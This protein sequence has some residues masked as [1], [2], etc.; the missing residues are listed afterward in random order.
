M[1]EAEINDLLCIYSSIQKTSIFKIACFLNKVLE[2][3][4]SIIVIDVGCAIG[5]FLGLLNHANIRS[6]GI[7]P[8]HHDYS[9]RAGLKKYSLLYECAIDHDDN[10]KLFN[11]TPGKDCSSL[12]DFNIE[13]ITNDITNTKNFYIPESRMIDS[14]SVVEKRIVKCK[15][16]KSIITENKLETC[17]IHILKVDCQGNDLN[18]VKSLGNYISSV[19]FIII[20]SNSDNTSTLYSNSSTFKDDNEYLTSNNFELIGKEVL[21]RDDYDCIYYNKGLISMILT[22]GK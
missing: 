9:N 19:L 13:K 20:E 1:C 18:V 21:L 22:P 10:D 3:T 6:I 7:D 16:L 11:I 5:D 15:T 4:S 12:C 14:C 17:I 2:N 8:L